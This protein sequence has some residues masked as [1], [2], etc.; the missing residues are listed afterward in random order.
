M[1]TTLLLVILL[2]VV[3]LAGG[4]WSY[5]TTRNN[6]GHVLLAV[7][8]IVLFLI[9]AGV[10]DV[11]AQTVDPPPEPVADDWTAIISTIVAAI[12]ALVAA[13]TPLWLRIRSMGKTITAQSEAI[14]EIIPETTKARAT[15]RELN[16]KLDTEK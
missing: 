12:V 16:A 14:K 13:V 7:A 15:A 4:G 5:Y 6:I 9:L 1:S 2:I 8:L 11:R 10:I 3:L